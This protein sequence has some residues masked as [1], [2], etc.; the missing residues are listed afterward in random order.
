MNSWLGERL[1]SAFTEPAVPELNGWVIGAVVIVSIALSVP[2]KT[3]QWFGLLATVVH[4][5]GHAV[6]AL[7]TG[8]VVNGITLEADHSGGTTT[9]GTSRLGAIWSGFWGYPVPA[10]YGAAM[11]YAGCAG[12]G[13][14]ALF[15]CAVLAVATILFI[16][17]GTGLLIILGV[18]IISTLL[19]LLTPHVFAG[20][21]VIVIGLAMLVAAVRDVVN[22][23]S[24]HFVR[25]DE[26][27]TSDAYILFRASFI[28]SPIWLLLFIAVIAFSWLGTASLLVS[29]I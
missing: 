22:V 28:P 2:R 27:E 16:R 11:V 20:H 24:L 26:L 4:E 18:S 12:Y 10:V 21:V 8:R 15:V 25:R 17:N 13:A 1:S 6:A 23:V 14:A 5:I 7:M 3:W 19:A 29:Y 9:E